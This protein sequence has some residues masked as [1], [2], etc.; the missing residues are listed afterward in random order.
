MAPKRTTRANPAITTTTTTTSVTNAQLEVLIEQGVAKTLAARDADKNTNDDDSH[1][2]GT[3][4]RRT[5]RVNR[6]CTYLDFMNCQPLNF[7][8]TKGVVELTQWF[9]KLE[10][11]FRISN[12]SVENQIKLSTCT[13]FRSALTYVGGL[14]DVIHG[15]VVASRPKAMQEAIKMVNELMEKRNNTLA[16]RQAE[17]KRKF[18][19]TSRNNQQQQNKRSTANVNTANNQRGNGTGQKPTCYEYGAQRHFKKDC[20]KLK[21]NNHGTQGGNATAP[22]KVYAVGYAGTNP[23]SNVITGTFLLNNRYASILFD[24]GSDRSFMSTTFSSQIAITPTTLDHY[25]DVE[26]ADGRIISDRGNETRLNIITCT[27][28]Q[29]YMQKGCHVFLAHITTKETEDKSEKKRLENNK[30]EHEEHNKAILELLKK[31]EMYAKFSKYKFWIPKVQFLGH[32]IDSLASYYR[33]FIEGFSKIAKSMTKFTLKGVKFY[34]GEKQEAAFQL[35]KQKLRSAPILALPEGSKDFVVYYNASHKGLGAVLIQGEKAIAYASLQLKIHEKNYMTH[36]LELGSELNMRQRRW[37][38]LLSE[39]DYEIRYHPGKANVVADV[40]SWKE[41]IKPIRVRALVMTIGLELP[42]QILNA[43]TKARKTKNIKN[44]DVGGMLV[45]NSKDLEKLGTEKLEPRADGTLCLNG[46]SWLPYY[47]DLRTVIM[48]ASHKSKYFIHPGSNKMYQDIKRLYWWPNMKADIATYVIKCLTCAKVMAKHQRPSGFLVQPKIPEWMWDNITI[49]FVTKLPKSSKGWINHLS[50]VE[51]SYNNSYHASIKAAP[52]EAL[53][54]RK[55]RS[56]IC[57]TKVRE[58]QLLDL[59]LIQETTDKIIQIKQRM[60]T[61]RDREK[62]YTDLKLKPMEFQIRDRVMLKVSPWKRV[63]RFGKRGKLN[64]RY[65]RPLKKC[66]ADEPLA[67][68]LDGLHFDDKLHFVEEPVEIMDQEVKRLKKKYPTSLHKDRTVIKCRNLSL[69]DKAHLMGKDYNTRVFGFWIILN[70]LS[71]KAVSELIHGILNLSE[72]QELSYNQNYDGNYYSH[73][74]PS[75]PCCDNYGGS[76]KTFQCQPITFQIDFSDS[77]Q[78]QTPQYPEIHLS[79]QETSDEVFQA[80]H[81]IQNKLIEECST[82]ICEE[83]KQSMEDT[84]LEL[85]KIYQEKEFLCIHVDIDDLI[86]SALN[87]KL[88]L[89]N[90]NSQHLDKKEQ[91]VKNV[92]EQPTER[93]NR[94]PEHLL[95]MGYEHLSITPK[96]E[97]DEVTKSNAE[98]L[99]PIQVN[100]SVEEENVVNQSEEEVDFED[101]SQIQNIVLREKLL[102]ITRLISKIESLNDNPTPDRVLNSFESDNSLSEKFSPEFETFCDHSKETRSGNTTHA[103]NSLPEYDSFCFEIEPDQERLINLVKNDIPDNLSNDS[104]LEED[105]LFLSNN[106]IPPGIENLTDDPEGDIHFLEEL[107]IDDSILSHESSDSN[108]KDNPLISRPPPKPPDVETDA[109]EEILVVMNNK[110]EDVDYSSFIFIFDKAFSLLSAESKDTI[111]DP[112]I[113][114]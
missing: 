97:S 90:S 52:F 2:S 46:R 19:D 61:V 18:D 72:S 15:N 51:F 45:E 86:E 91:E 63:V 89:I 110:D 92:V 102:S 32:V 58:A 62:S 39:Y 69:E 53:Y 57:W 81:S 88:L 10:T 101:I 21:Y 24:T 37:L 54:G 114:D 78:I 99:L 36:D 44:E 84:M 22:A 28:T 74:L 104:L 73:D 113:S 87:S 79:S 55:Y 67:V 109:G 9:E 12:C 95:S 75:L 13:L 111:F 83:Q 105:D 93:G 41:R 30:K 31:E 103:D 43:Q 16:E 107:L 98:N 106:S 64:P 17:N 50:L 60:Q 76:N 7:K 5:E 42:K 82:E 68:P 3:G 85:V 56:P 33:R 26:L 40:L 6:E 80:N 29:K 38:E 77:D 108:F 59:E 35:L 66:H 71:G 20:P 8:G 25:Y 1:V 23:D 100:A 65:V 49:D 47:G 94:K 14:P 4:A 70:K 96:T 11:V 34:W 48:H 27:K 112:S